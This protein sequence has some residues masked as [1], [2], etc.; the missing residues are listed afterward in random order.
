MS[1]P[2][3]SNYSERVNDLEIHAFEVEFG[4]GVDV[5][6]DPPLLRFVE[7]QNETWM[8]SIFETYSPRVGFGAFSDEGELEDPGFTFYNPYDSD[9]VYEFDY[10]TFGDGQSVEFLHFFDEAS[11]GKQFAKFRC[12]VG[13]CVGIMAA[14]AEEAKA[15]ARNK[16]PSSFYVS[17]FDVPFECDF[18]SIEAFA[19]HP[20]NWG[21]DIGDLKIEREQILTFSYEPTC[22]TCQYLLSGEKTNCEKCE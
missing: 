14:S 16:I 2:G 20:K 18:I 8:F 15:T 4:I 1:K 10:S 9:A 11:S 7:E 19:P 6:C 3:C 17:E 12:S 13:F 22:P 5:E 21:S